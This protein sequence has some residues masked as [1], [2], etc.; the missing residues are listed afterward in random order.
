MQSFLATRS[1]A[2]SNIAMPVAQL[3]HQRRATLS[4]TPT[5]APQSRQ[6]PLA[7]AQTARRCLPVAAAPRKS[8]PAWKADRG[9][10]LCGSGSAKPACPAATGAAVVA[11]AGFGTASCGSCARCRPARSGAIA[12]DHATGRSPEQ[13]APAGP[14][15]ITCGVRGYRRSPC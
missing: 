15:P 8:L 7:G 2:F 13:A 9:D 4:D 5:A 14:A 12:R 10:A 6:T 1:E 11:A 3:R